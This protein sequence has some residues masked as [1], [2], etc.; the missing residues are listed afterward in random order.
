M[1]CAW[2]QSAILRLAIPT[3]PVVNAP[4]S[5]LSGNR[6]SGTSAVPGNAIL[7]GAF[8]DA[9]WLKQNNLSSERIAW[10]Y[11]E[12]PF[13]CLAFLGI[14]AGACVLISLCLPAQVKT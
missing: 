8:S 1:K 11:F 5:S 14:L 2:P 6:N 10:T 3:G 12:S 13:S 4:I 9:L 7:S